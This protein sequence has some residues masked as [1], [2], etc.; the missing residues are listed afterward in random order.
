[1]SNNSVICS[2]TSKLPQEFWDTYEQGEPLGIINLDLARS[3]GRLGETQYPDPDIVGFNPCA[4][5]S[6][7]DKETCMLAELF[8]PNITTEEELFKMAT[9]L[10]RI[11]KHS[12]A[13]SCHLEETEAIVHK[14]MRMGIG[15]TGILQCPQEKIDWLSN[16]Y[17]YLREYD[18]RYSADHNWPTSIK[19]T[20]VKPSGSLS[21]LAGVTP[22]AH[23]SPAGPY[24]IRRMRIASDSFLVDMCRKN[25]YHV[26]YARG[27]DGSNDMTT[28]VVEFPCSVPEGTP[29][30]DSLGAI[31]HLEIVKNLQTIW[32]DN[33]VSCTVYYKKEELPAIKQWL[34]E[35]FTTSLKTVSFLLYYGHGFDQAP[36][37]TISKER[38]EEMKANTRP[39]TSVEIDETDF[40]VMECEGGA[41]PIK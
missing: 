4:E 33:S 16:C 20:T 29:I 30:G 28:M 34:K 5:Q 14:N 31:E 12:L 9:Y 32:S 21:L 26:E 22:G 35:N 41:C 27:F 6:L 19:L 8:L 11:C 13:L 36:Y 39:I 24:Y 3:C 25:G 37:E 23:P 18:K 15:I 40:D 2:N 1:M 38:Y 17:E 10:Y 7:C